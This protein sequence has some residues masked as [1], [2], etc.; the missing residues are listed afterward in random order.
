VS[1]PP[2]DLPRQLIT[3]ALEELGIRQL[4]LGIHDASFPSENQEEL[5]HG[6]PYSGGGQAFTGFARG[7]GFSGLMLGP[8]GRVTPGNP[9]PY[10][11]SLF[12]RNPLAIASGQLLAL[13]GFPADVAARAAEHLAEEARTVTAEERARVSYPRVFARQHRT[14]RELF[15]QIGS[16]LDG[17]LEAFRQEAWPWLERDVH[18]V[19]AALEHG[20]DD[21]RTW[22]APDGHADPDRDL[23]AADGRSPEAQRRLS[24]LAT[25]HAGEIRFQVLLQYLALGQHAALRARLAPTDFRLYGDMQIGFSVSDHW[26]YRSRFLDGYLL[27]A[28][29][30][31]TNPE[32]QPWGYPVLDPFKYVD[33]G[34]EPGPVLQLMRRRAELMFGLYD[35]LR[36]DHPHGLIDPWV[37]RTD[38]ADALFSVQHG[39]RLFGSP[40]LV[41]HP[42]LA[43][44]SVVRQEQLNPDPGTSRHAD[45]WVSSLDPAQVERYSILVDELVGAA[46]RLR[47]GR[48]TT[49]ALVCEVLSTLPYPVARVLDRHGLG[50]FRVTQ[51]V[52]LANP[53]DPYRSENAVPA[54]WIMVGTHD[55]SPLLAVVDRWTAQ[56]RLADHAAYL[57]GRLGRRSLPASPAVVLQAKLAE[58]FSSRAQHVLVFFTDLLGMREAYNRPGLISTENWSLRVPPDYRHG[59]AQALQRDEALNLPLAL[60][61]ALGAGSERRRALAARLAELALATGGAATRQLLEGSGT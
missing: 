52:D 5:G 51:K 50:R 59:Y 18:Y 2:V 29:P 49:E 14:L 24:Q 9:S 25:R 31:R 16:R 12:S 45:D 58:L 4:L 21:W 11:G 41:D 44:L 22:P 32:G 57:A 20:Q 37:Y 53:R 36:I 39:A 30:S 40:D 3:D 46:R 17:P 54:D 48:E 26:A 27:G 60:A 6:S 7:L 34:G 28:P 47:P 8:G 42:R 23:Y 35:A 56:G 38:H 1:S 13:P 43:S 33:A 61:V 55:T 19:A 10:D 15:T